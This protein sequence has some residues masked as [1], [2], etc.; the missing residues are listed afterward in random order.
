MA[1]LDTVIGDDLME[2]SRP[3]AI[4]VVAANQVIA[5]LEKA[6][7]HGDNRSHSA[8]ENVRRGST[9]QRSQI[10]LNARARG[11]AGPQVVVAFIFANFRLS[12]GSGR[13]NRRNHSAAAR[14]G[15]R[16]TGEGFGA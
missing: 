11:I 3:T 12:V 8:G 13:V 5:F 15:L 1:E 2:Q 6:L 7:G 14:A 10:P 9:F 16:S 4:H